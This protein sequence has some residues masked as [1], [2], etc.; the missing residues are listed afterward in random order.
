M[1]R[2]LIVGF[3]SGAAAVLFF[4]QGAAALLHAAGFTPRAP[5]SFAATQPWGVPLVWS[6]AFWGGVWGVVLAAA[7]RRLD[8]FAV[9]GAP[10]DCAR[11]LRELAGLGLERFVITSASFRADRDH[12]RTSEELLTGELLPALRGYSRE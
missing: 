6:L 10:E 7:V 2:W 3:L 8:R 4:H 1:K 5:Y 12:V 11:R 9:V